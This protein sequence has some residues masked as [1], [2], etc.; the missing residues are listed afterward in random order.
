MTSP[1]RR[2]ANRTH[3][4]PI[5]ECILLI[6]ADADETARV[7]GELDSLTEEKFLVGY[8]THQGNRAFG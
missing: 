7:L 8:R 1:R 2:P 5:S 3:T 6:A 4:P